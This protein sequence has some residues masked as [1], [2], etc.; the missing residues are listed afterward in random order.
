MIINKSTQI[1]LNTEFIKSAVSRSGMSIDEFSAKAQITKATYYNLLK[2][3]DFRISQLFRIVEV[4]EVNFF[5]LFDGDIESLKKIKGDGNVV[6][7]NSKHNNTKL[8]NNTQ[9]KLKT[10]VKLLELENESLKRE[11]ELLKG[12][13]KDKEDLIELLRKR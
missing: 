10:K 1:R 8:N 2:S 6:M 12:K 11:A 4:L 3:G 9:S 7:V 5:E 13:V